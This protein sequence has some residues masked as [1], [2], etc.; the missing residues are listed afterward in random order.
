MLNL[1]LRTWSQTLQA[2]LPVVVAYVWLRRHDDQGGAKSAR[3]ALIGGVVLT[4]LA[5]FWFQQ[6]EQQSQLEAG[7]AW[8][9]ATI[10]L[11]ALLAI[12][13]TSANSHRPISVLSRAALVIAGI[14]LILRQTMEIGVVLWVAVFELQ[15]G[16]AVVATLG[17]L[18]IGAGVAVTYVQAGRSARPAAVATAARAFGVLYIAQAVLYA[19][20]ESAES[21][22]L[23]FSGIL[24]AATEPYGPDGIYGPLGSG[25]VAIVPLL[26]GLVTSGRDATSR[27]ATRSRRPVA[28]AV[29]AIV[30][31]V[32]G[33]AAF[34]Y[35]QM[36]NDMATV[37]APASA[38]A[39]PAAA[40]TA[41]HVL[42]RRTSIE[43]GYGLM[44]SGLPGATPGTSA[45]ACE[46]IA[47]GGDRG[48]CLQAKRGLF[49][50]YRAVFFDRA[51]T[52]G[53]TMPLDGSPSRARISG[54]GRVGAVTV[55]DT[56][57]HSY[58]ATTFST[59]T[60]LIDMTTGERIGNLEDFSTWR[61]GT[62]I[63]AADFNFW[64][65]TFARDPSTFYAT[66]RTAGVTYLVRG[67]LALRK[68]T[69]LRE[70]VECPSLSPDNR[71]IAFKKRVG[72]ASAPWR[73]YVLDVASLAEQELTTEHRS[74]DDQIEWLD[75]R[76]VLYGVPR[77]SPSA[78]TDV[79][80]TPTDGSAEPRIFLAEAE[81]PV[82]VR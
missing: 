79:W 18:A 5:G 1:L 53:G 76:Q 69:V 17:A 15:S 51:L 3:L 65:V 80:V 50:T 37:I 21:G 77:P 8:V 59:I 62:R 34:R 9:A 57:I 82:V 68:L 14:I 60:L 58:S 33:F 10:A 42:F 41:G 56:G 13:P 38:S 72:P 25:L 66:M 78:V 75:D 24:H 6:V 16:E 35:R 31:A 70:N 32:A 39:G 22:W 44:A 27:P 71:R 81:S 30:F 48:I 40:A 12:T 29:L 47:Y 28:V 67:D 2:F 23:P 61:D 63:K 19:V 54:D 43:Q 36:S 4:P 64:G 45:L 52:A 20:H 73:L 46:R 49:T 7:L 55:F 74:I 26:V 11:L